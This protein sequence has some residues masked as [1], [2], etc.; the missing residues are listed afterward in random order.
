MSEAST[1]QFTT[2]GQPAFPVTDNG[3]DNQSASST[4]NTNGGQSSSSEGSDQGQTANK[5][6]DAGFAD[7]PRW[8]EREGDWT[9]RF[10][11]QEQRHTSELA[12]FRQEMEG[13]FNAGKPAADAPV[14]VPKWFGGDQE[15]W[16]EFQTWNQQLVDKAT[17]AVRSQLTQEEQQQKQRVD[18]ATSYFE[19]E[20]KTLETDKELN[21][22]GDKIDRNKLLKCALDHDLIDSKGRWNYRAAWRIMQASVKKPDMTDRK[23]LAAATTS[24]ERTI[25]NTSTMATSET[26][27]K[28]PGKRPW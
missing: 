19:E 23:N 16:K 9:K 8:K 14:E 15:Q 1:T 11:E 21:P 3:N 13:R 28:S 5:G 25:P 6:T 24:D 20:V 12:K 7:H 27:R 18:E 4:D 26:F 17:G 22:N 2:E 10:N